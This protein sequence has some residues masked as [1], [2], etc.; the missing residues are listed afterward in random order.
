MNDSNLSKRPMWLASLNY[1]YL[2]ININVLWILNIHRTWIFKSS[3]FPVKETHEQEKETYLQPKRPSSPQKNVHIKKETYIH[4]H[5][6]VHTWQRFRQSRRNRRISKTKP[7]YTKKRPIYTKR[8]LITPKRSYIHDKADE[9]TECPK[10]NF[11]HAILMDSKNAAM[12][13][14]WKRLIKLQISMK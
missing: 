2:W 1:D 9:I 3:Y 4:P 10:K 7:T 5:K 11:A 8:D 13:I 12:N 14:I 6:D